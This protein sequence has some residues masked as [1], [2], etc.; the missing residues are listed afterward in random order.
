M[1]MEVYYGMDFNPF[2]KNIPSDKLFAGTDYKQMENRLDFIIR[3]R[4]IGVFLSN[5]GM[6]KTSC[7]RSKL[8]SLP[9]TRYRIVY[10]CMTT[11]SPIDFYRTLNDQLGLEPAYSKSRLVKQIKEELK[12][13]VVENRMEII[14]AIDESQYMSR[15][16]IK[17][18]VMLMNFDY[19]S[20]DYCT[21]LLIGQTD[22]LR[23]LRYKNLEAFVQRI[24]MNYTFSGMDEKEVKEY[25]ED[26]LKL[27]N[28]HTEIFSEE[29]YHTLYNLSKGTLR[30]LNQL[31]NKSLI[32]GAKRKQTRIDTELIMDA[33]N[34]LLNV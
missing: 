24:N 14:I 28:C 30:V 9:D 26:R 23:M 27:V 21:L 1:E 7:L 6:G 4:G 34:E 2:S 25:V 17:E 20:K 22:F 10:I 18:F 12:R 13:T 29:S 31:I 11:V 33:K 5:P 16:L 15:E 8:E 19:D 3:T 32:I